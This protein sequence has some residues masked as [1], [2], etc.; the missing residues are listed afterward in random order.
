MTQHRYEDWRLETESVFVHLS[1]S[2]LVPG[3]EAINVLRIFPQKTSNN[4]CSIIS[5]S[6]K[7]IY[8][9]TVTLHKSKKSAYE[10]GFETFIWQV[11]MVHISDSPGK[12]WQSSTGRL[13]HFLLLREEAGWV[14]APG[15]GAPAGK[16]SLSKLRELKNIWSE[17][18]I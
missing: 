12:S 16:S 13:W 7:H 8:Q 9:V 6:A 4:C 2:C 15:T 14:T 5:Y 3:Q 17:K 11:Y 1:A 18:N 10:I